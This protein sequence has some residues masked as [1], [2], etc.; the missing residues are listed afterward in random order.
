MH[1]VRRL[2]FLRAVGALLG[3]AGISNIVG[4]PWAFTSNDFTMQGLL[5]GG[6]LILPGLAL[7]RLAESLDRKRVRVPDL[8]ASAAEK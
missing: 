1:F 3:F 7:M 8:Q 2:G 6:L 5:Y 4:L